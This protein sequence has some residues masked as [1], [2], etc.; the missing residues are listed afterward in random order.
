[1]LKIRLNKA[2]KAETKKYISLS[3]WIIAKQFDIWYS[4]FKLLYRQFYL[5]TVMFG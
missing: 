4:C 2:I 3:V 5:K 1:M